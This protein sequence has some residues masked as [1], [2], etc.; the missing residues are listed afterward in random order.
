MKSYNWR[1]I[2][3]LIN[4]ALDK[5][6]VFTQLSYSFWKSYFNKFKFKIDTKQTL[7]PAFKKLLDI[8]NDK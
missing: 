3:K 6:D 2:Q 7:T 4:I 8:N 5:K 1:D